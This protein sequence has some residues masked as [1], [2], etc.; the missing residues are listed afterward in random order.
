ME[1]Q[2]LSSL[3]EEQ[4]GFILPTVILKLLKTDFVNEFLLA[5]PRCWLSKSLG[6]ICT[7]LTE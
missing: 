7:G 4:K 3:E 2:K 1:A 6:V 5:F